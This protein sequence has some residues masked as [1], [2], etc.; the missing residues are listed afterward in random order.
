MTTLPTDYS[1]QQLVD[2]LQNEWEYL[3]HDDFIEGEDMTAEEHLKYL[4]SLTHSQLVDEIDVNDRHSFNEYM[5]I[6]SSSLF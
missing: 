6:N 2:A 5:S 3:I 4:Q 1:H